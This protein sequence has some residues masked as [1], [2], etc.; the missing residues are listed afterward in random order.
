MQDE[1]ELKKRYDD[2]KNSYNN[3]NFAKKKEDIRDSKTPYDPRT[4]KTL[5]SE[6]PSVSQSQ[7][8]P[9]KEPKKHLSDKERV[10][11]DK[12]LANIINFMMVDNQTFHSLF[13]RY[14]Y[15][16]DGMI[17]LDNME[18]AIYDDL[19]IKESDH[20]DLMIRHYLTSR[21]EVNI[22]NLRQDL[23]KF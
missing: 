21:Q 16:K 1:R 4:G 3:M 17:S 6:N 10:I 19:N 13:E 14:D 23:K 7:L 8:I 22:F 15:N 11:V 2:K 20:T 5:R 18:S 12:V 9:P